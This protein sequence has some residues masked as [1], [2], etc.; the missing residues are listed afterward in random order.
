MIV[1]RWNPRT[2]E[3]EDHYIKHPDRIRV[4][5]VD[6]DEYCDC[7]Q[8]G[9]PTLIRM[10]FRSLEIEGSDGYPF[11]VCYPCHIREVVSAKMEDEK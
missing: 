2:H 3:Y 11:S 10:S 8:C 6:L 4:Y 7:A 5:D 9:H 1:N